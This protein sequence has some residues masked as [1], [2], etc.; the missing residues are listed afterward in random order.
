[1][2]FQLAVAKSYNAWLDPGKLM[3]LKVKKVCPSEEV[4]RKPSTIR[5]LVRKRT[6]YSNLKPSK[7]LVLE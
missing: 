4:H 7:K 2:G 6:E 3:D 5:G 1:M